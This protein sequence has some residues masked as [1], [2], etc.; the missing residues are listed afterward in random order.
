MT[1]SGGVNVTAGPATCALCGLAMTPESSC[2]PGAG[3][4]PFGSERPPAFE[5]EQCHDCFVAR[6][7]FHHYGCDSEE[8]PN[9]GGQLLACDCPDP[10]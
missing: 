3:R 5:G 10:F 1:P 8:C 9:C 2:F 6:G 7:A 4:V